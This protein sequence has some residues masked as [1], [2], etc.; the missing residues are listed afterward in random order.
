M[1][2]H[3]RRGSIVVMVAVLMVVLLGFGA[4]AVD[5][6]QMQAYKSELR[7]TADAAALAAAKQLLDNPS[8]A[9]SMASA[10]V[11]DNSVMGSTAE[12]V[13]VAYGVYNP[14]N[15]SFTAVV[16]AVANA[17]RITVRSSGDFYLAQ[18]IGGR[19][20]A[21]HATATAWLPVSGTPCA[22]PWSLLEADID[23]VALGGLTNS[24]LRAIPFNLTPGLNSL[25]YIV[26]DSDPAAGGTPDQWFGAVNLP[27]YPGTLVGG[28]IGYA[29]NILAGILGGPCHNLQLG[30]LLQSKLTGLD[31]ATI[32]GVSGGG[33]ANLCASL[34]GDLCYNH[35]GQIGVAVRVPIVRPVIG[36]VACV[37]DVSQLDL[38]DILPSGLAMCHE[39][40]GIRTFVVAGAIQSGPQRG[41]IIA[42]YAGDDSVG[43]VLG[44]A[45]RPILVQ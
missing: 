42:L 11:T 3:E 5:V 44:Y 17:F 14:L 31:D 19:D 28:A 8:T 2:R 7:R 40:V 39:V 22:A 38:E 25:A 26:K 24:A 23:L 15:S 45:Q 27:P 18:L 34:R 1:R 32:D 43:P 41:R 20:F 4:F 35:G 6:A 36:S 30:D 37:T 12:I 29:Q 10:Y 9:L 21:V 13:E 16:P 33:V